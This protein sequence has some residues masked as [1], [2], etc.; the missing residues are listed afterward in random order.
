M[1]AR[2]L[3][4]RRRGRPRT[5]TSTSTDALGDRRR[6]AGRRTRSSRSRAS[7]PRRSGRRPRPTGSCRRRW[8]SRPGRRRR[9]CSR[10]LGRRPQPSWTSPLAERTLASRSTSST[11]T[12]PDA[13][14]TSSAP[15]RPA[16]RNAAE[17]TFASTSDPCGARM[18]MSNSSPLKPNR[19]R[20]SITM[21]RPCCSTLRSSTSPRI[22]STSTV[23]SATSA[24]STSMRPAPMPKRSFGGSGVA[25]SY[26]TATASSAATSADAGRAGDR[27][28][29]CGDRT[30]PTRG[31]VRTVQVRT[32]CLLLSALAV[33]GQP[34]ADA[35]ADATALVSP[36]ASALTIQVLTDTPSF[37]AAP[38]TEVFSESGRRSVMRAVRPSSAAGAGAASSCST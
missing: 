4:D 11:W 28:G 22:A 13:V 32:S 5:R 21:S 12:S 25:K 29:R 1:E 27:R 26:L 34:A 16:A 30:S 37:A 19:F 15:S 18:R 9:R 14:F 35:A 10:P 3:L 36:R 24:V 6:S 33:A 7:P 17:A 23:V 20:P 31:D 38:S 8:P 2:A